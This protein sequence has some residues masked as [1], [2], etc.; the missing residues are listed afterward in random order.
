LQA[1]ARHSNRNGNPAQNYLLCATSLLTTE[2]VLVAQNGGYPRTGRGP[3]P[4]AER[5]PLTGALTG[6][7]WSPDLVVI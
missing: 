6:A 5:D 1:Q 3:V 7:L 2:P 4:V